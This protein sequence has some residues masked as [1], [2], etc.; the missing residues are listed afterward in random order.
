MIKYFEAKEKKLSFCRDDSYPRLTNLQKA[1]VKSHWENAQR[2]NPNLFNSQIYCC[3]GVKTGL[4]GRTSFSINKSDYATYEWA[5]ANG[6]K[7][8]KGVFAMGDCVIPYEVDADSYCFALRG[9]GVAFDQGKYCGFAGVIDY[10]RSVEMTNFLQYLVVHGAKEV[11]EET[12]TTALSA[13]RLLGGYFDTETNKVEF[14]HAASVRNL[15]LKGGEN[16]RLVMIP[17]RGV[18]D[19]LDANS[20]QIE[21]STLNHLNHWASKMDRK[22]LSLKGAYTI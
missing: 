11:N 8:I 4:F 14:F 19:F 22:P 2:T 20:E 1:D 21:T 16:K 7:A 10:D 15:S 17:R 13:L 6:K 18:R 5:R 12:T 9:N 3:N